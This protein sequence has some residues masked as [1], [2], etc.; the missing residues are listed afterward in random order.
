MY[1]KHFYTK[2]VYMNYICKCCGTEIVS[3]VEIVECPKCES[4]AVEKK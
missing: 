2:E 3:G 4:T 1:Q